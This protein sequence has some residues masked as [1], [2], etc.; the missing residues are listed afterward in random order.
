MCLRCC[1]PIVMRLPS[2]GH[3][4]FCVAGLARGHPDSGGAAIMGVPLH[5]LV[6]SLSGCLGRRTPTRAPRGEARG[7]RSVSAQNCLLMCPLLFLPLDWSSVWCVLARWWTGPPIAFALLWVHSCR[8]SFGRASLWT[9]GSLQ[10]TQ[11]DCE[12]VCVAIA[13]VGPTM[14]TPEDLRGLVG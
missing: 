8:V 1:A 10:G 7:H 9:C 6:L 4:R 12:V 5:H 2:L 3:R 14:V 13:V 11:R